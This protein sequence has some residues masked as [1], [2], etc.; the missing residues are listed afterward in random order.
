MMGFQA[1]GAAPLVTGEEFLNQILLR[2][3]FGLAILPIGQKRSP[4]K[5]LV[6]ASL[7]P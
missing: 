1:A 7:I 6:K 5:K 3:Q 4:S 2:R